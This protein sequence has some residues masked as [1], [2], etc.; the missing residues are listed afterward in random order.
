[1]FTN[2]MDVFSI[3]GVIA[4]ACSVLAPALVWSLTYR[5]QPSEQG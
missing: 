4:I 5:P 1:M 2:L 3:V